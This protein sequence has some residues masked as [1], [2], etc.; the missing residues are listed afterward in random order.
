[1][2]LEVKLIDPR[3]VAWGFPHRGSDMAAGLDLHACLDEPL[4]LPAG[5]A[6]V[7]VSTGFAVRI[8]DPEWCGLVAPRSGAGHR[9][10]VLG[11]TIGIIDADYEGPILVSAWNRNA[12]GGPDITILPG[13]RIAQ[14]VFVR[15]GR[16]AISIVTDFSGASS[17]GESGFG[18]TGQA[19]STPRAP[20]SAR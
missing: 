4:R 7:L 6:P 9:G 11:N 5:A 17:R 18:S 10:L 16:P 12:P 2:N 1:M 14:L 3:L 20:T 15:I 13:E 19:P 8:G